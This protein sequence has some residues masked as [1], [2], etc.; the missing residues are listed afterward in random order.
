MDEIQ[1][2]ARLVDS[3]VSGFAAHA[4]RTT[5]PRAEVEE[6][7]ALQECE[8]EAHGLRERAAVLTVAVTA[9]GAGA[10]GAS[11]MT[12]G[13]VAGVSAAPV[14]FVSD[15]QSGGTGEPAA[16]PSFASDVQSGGTGEPAATPSFASDVQSGGTGE[17]AAT[18]SFVSDVASG[19][20][21]EPVAAPASGDSWT[22]SPAA[23]AGIAA[24]AALLISAA[25]FTLV[26]SRKRSVRPA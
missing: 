23:D 22:L 20:L 12:G 15:V 6:E 3:A 8:V 14:T 18:P 25:G 21:G 2:H 16:T 17:P 5:V 19:G 1:T 11:A 4:I 13:D 10:G 7:L 9:V 24:G 26:R